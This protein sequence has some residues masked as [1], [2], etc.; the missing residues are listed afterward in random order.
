MEIKIGDHYSICFLISE[1]M[2]KDFATITGDK[3]P[4]H[5]DNEF[6]KKTIF[7]KRIAQGFLV[8]SLISSVLGNHFPGNGTIYLSQ[9]L[10]F[11]KPVFINDKIKVRIDVIEITKNN[12][13]KLK[14]ECTNQL[15]EV[16]IIGEA[17][18]IP[19]KNCSLINS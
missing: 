12:W 10:R 18:A 11:V 15:G 17:T 5:L 7:K 16:V 8:G 3:N 6:A 2:I 19:P 9:S 14:T 13:L 4:I 1:K